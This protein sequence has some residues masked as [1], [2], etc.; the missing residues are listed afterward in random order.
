MHCQRKVI[1]SEETNPEKLSATVE[2]SNGHSDINSLSVEQIAGVERIE[3]SLVLSAEVIQEP[4]VDEVRQ[5]FDAVPATFTDELLTTEGPVIDHPIEGLQAEPV[6][7][8]NA[9]DRLEILSQTDIMATD[10]AAP[11]T[12]NCE[13]IEPLESAPVLLELP[14]EQP[15]ILE[16]TGSPIT[17]SSI[18]AAESGAS[19][20][21][22]TTE[23]LEDP[24]RS[25]ETPESK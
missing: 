5:E 19:Q 23:L 9:P 6:A 3:E 14:V 2:Y 13:V 1:V 20:T 15:E 16:R 12:R 24:K 4:R 10:G 25:M 21:N 22:V 7:K 8:D 11:P 17:G 18:S